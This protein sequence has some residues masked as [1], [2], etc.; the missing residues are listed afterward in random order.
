M[1]KKNYWQ[2]KKIS[3]IKAYRWVNRSAGQN[4]PE[5]AVT[6]GRDI[7]GSTIYVGRAFHDGDM[8][9]AKVIPDKNIAYVCHNGEEH[10][11]H[12]FEVSQTQNA[13]H[14]YIQI[15]QSVIDDHSLITNNLED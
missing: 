11:K 14:H 9:P 5:T 15:V 6:G 1:I 7:D 8:I 10:Q 3:F 2:I 4:L 12:D 13:T